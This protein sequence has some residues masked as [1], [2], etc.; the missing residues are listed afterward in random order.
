MYDDADDR[1]EHELA[2]ER[3]EYTV[4]DILSGREKKRTEKEEIVQRMIQVLA[5]EYRYP[6]DAMRRD[7]AVTVELDGRRRRKSA[8]LVVYQPGRP[9]RLEHADRLV[10]VQPPGVRATDSSRGVEPL[11]DLL[12]AVRTCEFGLWTNGRDI[13]YVRKL[14]GPVQ[15]RFE[16]LSDFPGNGELLDDLNRPDRRVARVAVAEDLRETV[17]RCPTTSTATNR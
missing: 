4:F 12:D 14:P 11:K 9:H 6:L 10:V 13:A 5:A 17:L 16:E 7:V 15:S 8:D 2:E 3:Q 1:D